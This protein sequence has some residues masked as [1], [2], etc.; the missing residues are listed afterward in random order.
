LTLGV[1]IAGEGVRKSM[2]P[3]VQVCTVCTASRAEYGMLSRRA[4]LHLPCR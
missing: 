1:P 2:Y 3:T 4:L